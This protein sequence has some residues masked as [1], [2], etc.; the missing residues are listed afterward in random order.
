[1]KLFKSESILLIFNNNE[2]IN[3]V[4]MNFN[5]L[6]LDVSH[7]KIYEIKKLIVNFH[8]TLLSTRCNVFKNFKTLFFN[9]IILNSLANPLNT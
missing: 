9:L 6:E 2:I 5:E 1:M 3:V 4:N 7:L 8:L